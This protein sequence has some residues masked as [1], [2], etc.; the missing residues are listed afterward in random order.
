MSILQLLCERTDDCM[1]TTSVI[2]VGGCD[3]TRVYPFRAPTFAVAGTPQYT[4]L[5]ALYLHDDN[6]QL[7]GQGAQPH[8]ALRSDG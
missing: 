8:E 3:N 7:D 1:I 6:R 2:S 5:L 4:A